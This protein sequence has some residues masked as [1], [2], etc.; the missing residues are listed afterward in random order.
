VAGVIR[1]SEVPLGFQIKIKEV[2]RMPLLM[3]TFMGS[4][5]ILLYPLIRI[6]P[7][8][9]N[10]LS[11]DMFLTGKGG[12]NNGGKGEARETK[13][14]LANAALTTKFDKKFNIPD[15]YMM[16]PLTK[17]KLL[18]TVPILL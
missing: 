10:A 5:S 13:R 11:L 1:E 12:S 8:I 6:I 17:W 18:L 9:S 16:N 3:T 4:M 15:N 14:Q 7:S 2:R